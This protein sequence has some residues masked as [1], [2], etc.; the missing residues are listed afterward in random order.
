MRTENPMPDF[1]V[2]IPT[3]SR[4]DLLQ[5]CLESILSGDLLPR[6]IC[7]VDNGGG[8][9]LTGHHLDCP[10]RV[11]RP[12]RNLGV[13]GSWNLIHRLYAPADIIYCNDDVVVGRDVLRAL[14]GSAALF[15]SPIDGRN[16]W[17]CFLQREPVWQAVGE[18]DDGFWPAY[19]E[20][21]DYRRRMDLAGIEAVVVGDHA[22]VEHR[23]SSTGGFAF[24]RF[25]RNNERYVRKWGGQP[26]E[27]RYDQPWNGADHDELEMYYRQVCDHPSDINEHCPTLYLLAAQCRDVTDMGCRAG[28]STTALLRGRPKTL[29]C[30]DVHRHPEFDNLSRFA[31]RTELRFHLGNVLDVEIAPTDLLFI[32]TYHV[33]EQLRRELELHAGRVRRFIALH[34][35]TTFGEHGEREGS[36]GLWPAV[37]EFLADHPEWEIAARYHHNHGL[38]ILEKTDQRHANQERY[39]R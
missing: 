5:A 8:F 34:D 39:G 13:A 10:T 32:D 30:Y 1:I 6:E 11:V 35:T 24:E 16:S 22:G 19:Y 37:E 3:L 36:R 38:T 15:G 20:D 12:G 23:V 25:G 4:Y 2:A 29:D 28:V 7:I 18:Y 9:E 33:Y 17:S 26:G 14:V 31:G 27:E 21:N